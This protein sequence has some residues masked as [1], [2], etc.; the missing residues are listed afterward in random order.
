MICYNCKMPT[1]APLDTFCADR[2][3]RAGPLIAAAL[4]ALL[5]VGSASADPPGAT[6][7]TDVDEQ[8]SFGDELSV[9]WVLVPAVVRGVDGLAT[10]LERD[11]FRLAVDGQ[12]TPIA[13]FDA[14]RDVPF[15]LVVLQDLSGSMAN[16]GKLEAGRR[17]LDCVTQ[18][19]S[20]HDQV[21]LASFAAGRTE[22]EVPF[23]VERPVL[24][25]AADRWRAWGT[26][27]LHDAVAWLPEIRLEARAGRVAALLVTDG[28]DNASRLDPE[29][30]RSMVRQAE[31]PVY[32][33]ALHG[34]VDD[35]I[36]EPSADDGPPA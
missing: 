36:A 15:S 35:E 9:S 4:G 8:M 30:V 7:P 29:T 21:A 17:A 32:V 22:V 2:A 31:V 33:L 34:V 23:T 16:G 12:P 10:G 27:A 18:R 5:A 13:S 26:T 6:A 25:E 1:F 24:A 28:R 14:D 3:R 20:A 11:D 19:A